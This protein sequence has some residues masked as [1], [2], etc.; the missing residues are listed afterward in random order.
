MR[1]RERNCS[2]C[3]YWSEML[4]QSQGHSIEAMCL[5]PKSKSNNFAGTYTFGNDSCGEWA[6]NTLGAVDDPPDYGATVCAAYAEQAAM[7]YANGAPKFALDGTML[8]DKGSRSIFDDV[9][10]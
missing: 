4:A 9:D 1:T 10:E 5:G 8:D 3:R 2:G 7:R 6:K